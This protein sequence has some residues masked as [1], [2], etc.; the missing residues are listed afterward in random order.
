MP[1]LPVFSQMDYIVSI[2]GQIG[3]TELYILRILWVNNPMPGC[4]TVTY[5]LATSFYMR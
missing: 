5:T 4:I 1:R 2:M 3:C